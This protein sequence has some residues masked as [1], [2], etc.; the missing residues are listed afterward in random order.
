MAIDSATSTP[1]TLGAALNTQSLSKSLNG[2]GTGSLLGS[3]PNLA[4]GLAT[5][6]DNAARPNFNLAFNQMQNTI[7]DRMN[8]KVTEVQDAQ[9]SDHTNEY[10]QGQRTKLV[11]IAEAIA[12]VQ[13]STVHNGG[14]NDQIGDLLGKLNTSVAAAQA[15]DPTE[16]NSILASINELS[17]GFTAADGSAIDLYITDGTSD[18]KKNGVIR[19][20]NPDG[21]TTRAT[22]FSDFASAGDALNAI[23]VGLGLDSN[24]ANAIQNRAEILATIM[25]HTQTSIQSIDTQLQA[26]DALNMATQA[27]E[28]AKIKQQ[29][30]LMLQSLSMAFEQSQNL[31]DALGAAM[32]DSW[33]TQPGSVMNL[34][35]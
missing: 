27:G 13:A 11:G 35:T 25:N 31:T 3:G 14:A 26:G 18:L 9:A 6:A 22:Q 16:F 29:Y 5:A 28:I 19:V 23:T 10:L 17:D 32:S 8:K 15:G 20:T 30:S 1:T 7:I 24:V 12:P 33:G 21:S 4:Q 2:T 34:F